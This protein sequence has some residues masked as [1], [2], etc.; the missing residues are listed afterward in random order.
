MVASTLGQSSA[1][2]TAQHCGLQQAGAVTM[3]SGLYEEYK[4]WC[5]QYFYLPAWGEHR[6]VGGIFFDDLP[7]NEA[8]FNAEKVSKFVMTNIPH[9]RVHHS[10]HRYFM[11][12]S[13]HG[14]CVVAKTAVEFTLTFKRLGVIEVSGSDSRVH[15]V[16]EG[17][18]RGVHT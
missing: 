5:D 11:S 18:S 8:D 7:S 15:A 17:R 3:Q 12:C 16:C 13:D 14:G 4:E 2:A 1:S 9:S 10:N 6:G